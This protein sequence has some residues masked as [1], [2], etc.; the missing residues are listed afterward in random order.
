MAMLLTNKTTAADAWST[1]LPFEQTVG[2]HES[3]HEDEWDRRQHHEPSAGCD[4]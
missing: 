2:E 1:N 3:G 4:L